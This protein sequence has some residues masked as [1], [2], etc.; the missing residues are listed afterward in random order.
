M[1]RE[2]NREREREREKETRRERD[3][4]VVVLR[5]TGFITKLYHIAV[6]TDK[7]VRMRVF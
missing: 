5:E 7:H 1:E 4:E 2:R 3:G 6:S